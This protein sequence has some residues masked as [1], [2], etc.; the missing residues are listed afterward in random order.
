MQNLFLQENRWSPTMLNE[1]YEN[2][3]V[4][5]F[6]KDT[7]INLITELQNNYSKILLHY[8][9]SSFKKFGLYEKI[10]NMLNNANIEFIELGGVKANPKADLV[11]KG[12]EICRDKNIDFILAVGGGS[13]IDSAKAIAVGTKYSG[14]FFDFYLK[15]SNPKEALPLG[16]ILT[17][18]GSGSETSATSVITKTDIN[19]KLDFAS[20]LIRAKFSLLNP[21]NT[22]SVPVHTTICGI[23]DSLT[24][25]FE[26]Y[27]SNTEFVDCS[28][29]LSEALMQTLMKYAVLIKDSPQNYDYRAEIMWACKMAS[30]QI[31]YVGRKQDWSCHLISHEI[32]ALCDKPHGE[33]LSAIFP[34]WMKYCYKENEKLFSQ[35]AKR[36]FNSDNIEIGIDRFIEFLK[37]VNMPTSLKEIG[38]TNQS[39]FETVAQNCS[40]IN[41]SGTIGNFKR[42]N[43]NDII[44][45]LTNAI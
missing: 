33:I 8:G 32:G 21:Q 45:I 44:Q 30:D 29:R 36:V 16:V 22:L 1:K 23:I 41:P 15:E 7:E 19:K 6:G 17:N 14:D 10:T 34:S 12:I 37:E 38:F 39:D 26:R 42:L 27:F 4:F 9:A 18:S 3:T 24:H 5:Y 25:I 11:Y 20:N 13:V 35:F 28:D 2:K 31:I 43:K 40:K